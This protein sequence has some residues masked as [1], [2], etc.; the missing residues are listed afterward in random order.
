MWLFASVIKI[1][2]RIFQKN[3][4]FNLLWKIFHDIRS[5]AI[6]WYNVEHIFVKSVLWYSSYKVSFSV[7]LIK[8]TKTHGQYLDIDSEF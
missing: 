7:L 2:L 8:K 4:E 3:S 5:W 1:L 6:E